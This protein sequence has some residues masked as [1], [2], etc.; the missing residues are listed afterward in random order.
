MKTKSVSS[1][2]GFFKQKH[3]QLLKYIAIG[4]IVAVLLGFIIVRT[5]VYNIKVKI[6]NSLEK[7]FSI[8]SQKGI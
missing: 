1:F 8:I 2:K 7:I 6:M 5:S 3:K 4:I